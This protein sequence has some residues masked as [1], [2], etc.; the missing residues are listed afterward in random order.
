MYICYAD[1]LQLSFI[2]T[3]LYEKQAPDIHD[4]AKENNV[5]LYSVQDTIFYG[6][7]NS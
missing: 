6:K 5:L 1:Q 3:M 4:L 2:E 7:A